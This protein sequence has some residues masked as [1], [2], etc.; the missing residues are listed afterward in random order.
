MPEN[1]AI[2]PVKDF[3]SMI[4]VRTPLLRGCEKIPNQMVEKLNYIGFELLSKTP[5]LVT[6]LFGVIGRGWVR[7]SKWLYV[8]SKLNFLSHIFLL[9]N[10]LTASKG[11][12]KIR[13]KNLQ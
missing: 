5:L 7:K 10:F 8:I 9:C 6:P 12:V 11:E 4:K 1:W 13:I 2:K 3:L